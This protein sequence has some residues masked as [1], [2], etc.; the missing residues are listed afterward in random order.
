MEDAPQDCTITIYH[1][2]D[3]S[4]SFFLMD[5]TRPVDLTDCI[6]ELII[7]PSFD[8]T[9]LIRK[10]TSDGGAAEIIIDDAEKGAAHIFIPKAT[11]AT[12]LPVTDAVP[13]SQFL[14]VIDF[15]GTITEKW[16]GPMIV[17]P[18]KDTA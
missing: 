8:H 2:E 15:G 18:G 14:R 11:I 6:V 3:W 10:L 16:R 5:G 7:R 12:D 13:W 9:T 1:G 4:D 17:K